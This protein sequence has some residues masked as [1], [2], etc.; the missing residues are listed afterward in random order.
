MK[1]L[2]FF[3]FLWVLSA[4]WIRIRIRNLKADPYPAT[5]INADPD[6][7][8]DPKPWF[9]GR[10][11]HLKAL[12]LSRCRLRW[13]PTKHPVGFWPWST[14]VTKVVMRGSNGVEGDRLEAGLEKTRVFF[15]N[16]PS[17]FFGFFLSFFCFFLFFFL[18]FFIYLPQT[19][20]FLGFFSFKNT[21]IGASRL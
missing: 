14:R 16:Q 6:T 10:F 20:E 5:Q 2:D 11:P 17:G 8:L 15:K 4:S 9:R 3:L 7:D 1:I 12:D 21:F 19:R 13:Y 18:F